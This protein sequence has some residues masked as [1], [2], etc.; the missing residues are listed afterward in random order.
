MKTK[1][2]FGAMFAALLSVTALSGCNRSSGKDK[3]DKDGNLILELQNLYF[4]ADFTG[5]DMYS[6]FLEKK[7]GVKL[8]PSNYTYNDW[9]Q[10]VNIAIGGNNILDTIHYNLKAYNFGSTY[11]KWINNRVVKALPED[12][13]RWPE[14]KKMINNISNVDALKMKD[15]DDGKMKLFG[16]PIANDI[17]TPEKDF[18]H[19]TYVYRRDWVKEI[20]AKNASKPGYTPLYKEGDVYTWD[21]FQ[22]ILAAFKVKVAEDKIN[23]E[24]VMVDESWGFPSVTNFYKDVPH[25]FTKDE[26]GKA[27]N[28]FTSD[29]YIAG[30]E[31]AKSFVSNIY[32][33]QDQFSYI[34]TTANTKYVNGL[35]GI[36]YDNFN[37]SNYITLRKT[38]KKNN[39]N[40]NFEDGTALMKVMGPDGNFAL[41]GIENWFSMTMF[42][43][44]ISDKKM[45]KILD[46]LDYLLSE[47]GTRLA[48][49]GIEGQDYNI[50]NGE[51]E[52][53]ESGWEKIDGT[54]EYSPKTNGAKYLRYMATLGDDTK[55]Y[56]PFT[57]MGAYN[58]IRAWQD[59]MKAAKLAGKL[60]VVKEP[61]DIDWMSTPTKNSK[62]EGILA[63]ANKTALK[64]AYSKINSID[65]YKAE[66]AK[67][68]NWERILKEINDKLGK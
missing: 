42:N 40:V 47:E 48:V 12:L 18:S 11:E 58:I 29:Q 61:A 22:R 20:D 15:P 9:D 64:Y 17:S 4:K 50:I 33:S 54:D 8:V 43:Y 38:F 66:F 5:D 56:D 14:L 27:I 26:N 16:I 67:D 36:L 68:P 1:A 37:L 24:V 55:S 25:C 19:F 31:T 51:V 23:G 34:E 39:K 10:E 46:I 3:Y 41:E 53:T 65:A 60:R 62:T 52:L 35:A 59:E 57:D 28:A 49:Y 30:L 44:D 7:F 6:E 2:L 21:E 45:E 13:S 63:D 32:Y